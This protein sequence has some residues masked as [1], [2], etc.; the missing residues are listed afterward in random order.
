MEKSVS[1]G[2][3]F[4]FTFFLS[5]ISGY[6]FGKIILELNEG[7]CMVLAVVALIATLILESTLFIIKTYKNDKIAL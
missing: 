3:S 6:F 2:V 1:F 7:L 5:G 4:I